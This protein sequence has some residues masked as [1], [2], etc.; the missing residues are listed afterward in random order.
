MNKKRWKDIP[1]ARKVMLAVGSIMTMMLA[2]NVILYGQVNKTIKRMDTVYSSNV[3]LTE[4]SD[5][6]QR[7]QE[8]LYAY[9][10]VKSSDSLE[11]YYRSKQNYVNLLDK[12]SSQISSNPSRLLE[13]NIK[14]MSE[15]YASITE[16]AV[17]AKR[18]RNVEK[19]KELYDQ[20][21]K[22]YGYINFYINEL[23]SQ[24]F[25]NNSSSYQTLREM[26]E[27][28]EISSL[29]L[30]VLMMGLGAMMLFGITKGMIEPLTNLAETANLVGKG[31]FN[32]KMPRTDALDEVGIV[33]RA[34]NTMVES[35]EEYIIRTKESMEKEQ[36]MM[37]KELLMENH[38]KEAQ[39]KYL[40]SQINPHF[41]FN[42]LNAGAQL[43]MMEDAEKTCIFVEKM[44]DFFR[45]NVKKG[46]ED[47]SLE[48]E[49]TAVDNYIYILN[50][51]F[52]GDIHFT[53][54]VDES[55]MDCRIPSM[56][57][58]P[59]VENAVNH[60]IRNIEVVSSNL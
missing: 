35:L 59:I 17:T 55:L 34:F 50:V 25:R 39:L 24:Q 53:K 33:T 26:L 4:L 28:L 48:E 37:E 3:N 52:A 49:L 5:S 20:S 32:V 58:Q 47:A 2:I 18:S 40:Q 7:V 31:N 60:G 57:L 56:I 46:L 23:N 12:L 42:S 10:S 22:L 16:E 6:L 1:L 11:S 36:Q 15:T 29:V 27:Y 38:L 13:K 54:A 21:R 41:L 30:M 43:A 9:L 8:D 45:Y 14:S 44:A 19:Y 51:R